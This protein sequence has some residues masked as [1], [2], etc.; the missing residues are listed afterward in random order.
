MLVAK[1]LAFL[2]SFSLSLCVCVSLSNNTGESVD[3]RAFFDASLD[4]DFLVSSVQQKPFPLSSAG[5]T[6]SEEEPQTPAFPQVAM[7]ISHIMI[8]MITITI[9]LIILILIMIMIMIIITIMIIELSALMYLQVFAPETPS[10]FDPSQ[11][12]ISFASPALV[13]LSLTHSHSLTLTLSLSFSFSLSLSLSLFLS[14]SLSL[15]RS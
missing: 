12:P 15:S 9:I 3:A 11:T 6:I 1:S 13:S 10:M 14:F 5:S 8:T 7:I 4:N 2:R